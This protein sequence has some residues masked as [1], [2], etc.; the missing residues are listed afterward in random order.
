MPGCRKDMHLC[1]YQ[2]NIKYTHVAVV[3]SCCWGYQSAAN[4]FKA[5]HD[6]SRAAIALSLSEPTLSCSCVCEA[7]HRGARLSRRRVHRALVHRNPKLTEKDCSALG[8]NYCLDAP[9]GLGQVAKQ[10]GSSQWQG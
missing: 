5:A 8:G 2:A 3:G 4:E 7:E 10:C 6:H 9:T 1:I